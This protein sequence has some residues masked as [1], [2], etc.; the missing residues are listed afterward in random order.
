MSRGYIAAAAVFIGVLAFAYLIGSFVAVSFNI[1]DWRAD[2]R[3]AMALVGSIVAGWFT[4]L[5]LAVSA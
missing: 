4:V 5:F 1:A 3:I 2:G